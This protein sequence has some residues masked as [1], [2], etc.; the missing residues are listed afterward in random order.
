MGG[1]DRRFQAR[2]LLGVSRGAAG[3][4]G[5]VPTS[6]NIEHPTQQDQG[7]LGRSVIMSA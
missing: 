5:L 7:I 4:P 1:L 6:G 2:V 3:L